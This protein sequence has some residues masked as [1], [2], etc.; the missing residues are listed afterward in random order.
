[1]F[2]HG[3]ALSLFMANWLLLTLMLWD[4]GLLA[5]WQGIPVGVAGTIIAKVLKLLGQDRRWRG[6]W[7]LR[8]YD[9]FFLRRRPIWIAIALM[10][11]LF[12]MSAV[13]YVLL[14]P[15]KFAIQMRNLEGK[16]L[17]VPVELSV[18]QEP[19]TIKTND[20]GWAFA[21]VPG[22]NRGVLQFQ[23][24]TSAKVDIQL[25]HDQLSTV[26]LWRHRFPVFGDPISVFIEVVP[27]AKTDQEIAQ[28]LRQEAEQLMR[29]HKYQEACPKL[30]EAL[31]RA[32]LTADLRKE[33]QLLLG[34]CYTLTTSVKK[35]S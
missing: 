3:W 11:L 18:A 10:V 5:W 17:Q 15:L 28:E 16:P 20:G 6:R 21:E 1:M 13:Y 2:K 23:R 31:S 22:L 4:Y 9:W 8:F 14:P 27:P 12:F 34:R 29:K 30:Q 7:V 35:M 25:K 32:G 24:A 19:G 33:L 26:F